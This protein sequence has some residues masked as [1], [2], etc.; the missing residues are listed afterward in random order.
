VGAEVDV[1]VKVEADVE[2][3]VKAGV[4][5]QRHSTPSLPRRPGRIDIS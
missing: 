4:Q 2:V 3:K 1:E 5:R